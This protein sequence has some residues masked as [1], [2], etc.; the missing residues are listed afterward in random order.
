MKNN[1]TKVIVGL[2]LVLIVVLGI[3]FTV[4][5]PPTEE[6]VAEEPVAEEPVREP[7]AEEPEEVPVA[8]PGFQKFDP[9]ITVSVVRMVD[10][11]VKFV[12]GEDIYNNAWANLIKDELGITLEYDWIAATQAHYDDRLN[13]SI[14]AGDIPDLMQVNRNQMARLAQTDLIN[15]DLGPVFEQ[16]A[17]PFLKQMIAQEG[18]APID[19][20]TFDGSLIAIPNTGSSID[21]APMMWIRRDWMEKLGKTPPQTTDDLL[22]LIDAF[23]T[24]DPDG[25]GGR[26]YGI[27]LNKELF[28]GFGGFEGFA[29]AFGAY[30]GI[31]V[32]DDTGR[33]VYG[34][35]QPEM[36]TVLLKLQELYAAGK[37]DREFA[38]K[39]AGMVSEFTSAGNIGIQFGQMWNPLWPL[40]ASIDNNPEANWVAY[41]IPS[42]TDLSARPQINLG[43]IFYY[44]SNK[45][46]EHPEA[47]VKMMNLF[48]QKGWDGT[49][50][51]YKH[52]FNTVVE[53]TM[54][55]T[56]KF[57][58][59]QAWP[60]RKNLDMHLA[61][62]DAFK[63]N[64]TSNLNPE[65]LTNYNIIKSFKEGDNKGWGMARVFAEEGSFRITNHYQ[66]ENLFL[67][68]EFFGGDTT[69][70]MTKGSAIRDLKIETFTRIIMGDPIEM[71]DQFVATAR[72]LGGD[73]IEE[74]VNDWYGSR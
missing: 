1:T 69:T 23:T 70:M 10:D 49:I 45:N 2:A 20:A 18:T 7:V 52:Y 71:F 59:A 56:F 39:D 57:A 31:W 60:A 12:A 54:Y 25:H 37:I 38:V 68:N 58:F 26:Y 43:T 41:A 67:M 8:D 19:S 22:A 30:P 34:S 73:L 15:K 40:Q 65:Q 53:G 42:S 9:P 72:A 66:I 35:Y 44:V 14:A 51:E 46:F 4:G 13:I 63:N 17:S 29:N 55:E 6:P 33:L 48:V 50:E 32:K 47:L 64:D 27:A 61:I 3:W 5:R 21:G 62:V 24:Q 74:E 36:R 16:Y 11:T 28:H